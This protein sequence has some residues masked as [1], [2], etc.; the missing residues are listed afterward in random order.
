[1][2][3]VGNSEWTTTQ[4]RRSGLAQYAKSIRTIHYGLD[5]EQFTPIDK[6]IARKALQIPEGK[7]VVG[8]SCLNFKERRKG[9]EILMEALKTFPANEILLLVLGA[10]K[11]PASGVET[12][13]MGSF[14]SSRLQSLFY[15]ALDVFAM[16]SQIETFGNVAMEAMACETP[17]VAYPAGGLADVVADGE[18]GLVEREIGSVAGFVR[19]LDWMKKHPQERVAMGVA[20]RKR[21]AQNFSDSLMARRYTSLYHELVPNEKSF[22]LP[23]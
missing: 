3:F 7:F 15:S 10:G 14:N 11:W 13:A 8:F 17:V 19:M 9:A 5:L 12:I 20:G 6:A 21:V 2:H 22:V 1:M 16:P 23:S 18:T 4:A